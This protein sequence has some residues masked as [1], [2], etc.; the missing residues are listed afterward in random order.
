MVGKNWR[1]V[2]GKLDQNLRGEILTKCNQE[3]MQSGIIVSCFAAYW[4]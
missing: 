1:C 2:K 4:G 3:I